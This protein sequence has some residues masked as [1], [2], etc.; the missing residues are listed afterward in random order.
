MAERNHLIY[1]QHCQGAKYYTNMLLSAAVE[2]KGLE[3]VLISAHSAVS[4]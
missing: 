4:V 2:M 3:G 1:L